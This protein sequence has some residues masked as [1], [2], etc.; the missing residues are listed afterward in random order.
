MST[1][2]ANSI[3]AFPV[4][5][6]ST[7][8]P[9]AELYTSVLQPLL[10]DFQWGTR[11]TNPQFEDGQNG[12]INETSTS[13][14]RY[15]GLT[16]ELESVQFTSP[17]HRTW[18]A[19]QSSSTNNQEDIILTFSYTNL[20]S[21]RSE[22]VIIVVPILRVP[23]TTN[24]PYFNAFATTNA[25]TQMSIS[26]VI[27]SGASTLFAVYSTCFNGTGLGTPNQN[28]LNVIAV[29][30]L[31]VT[32][33]TMARIKSS[34]NQLQAGGTP[35]PYS[36]YVAPLEL[37]ISSQI[38]TISTDSDFRLRVTTT[39]N[40][41]VPPGAG[42]NP[43]RD[44]AEETVDAYKCV[45]FD[46]EKQMLNGKI[47]LDPNTGTPLNIVESQ[48]SD[49][50]KSIETNLKIPAEVYS[51]YV[52]TALAFFFTI[53]VVVVVIYVFIGAA[54]GPSMVGHGGGFFNRLFKNLTN[55]PAYSVIGI[56]CGF[57]GFMIGMVLKYRQ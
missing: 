4:G 31:N 56:L 9:T 40:I 35:R 17:T 25:P 18:I 20:G 27:P 24:S 49:L 46:P 53:I 22:Y 16:Y 1:C 26:S 34:F 14:L 8:V 12:L 32:D 38:R 6:S 55:I 29:N 28:V 5:L 52:S 10:F 33:L 11:S 48:R 13:S 50:K 47:K 43:N 41:L 3:Q 23:E 36:A 7:I 19:P 54:I 30:G 15:N 2:P 37:T 42:E 21:N 39:K 44:P 45:P 57:I 51:K